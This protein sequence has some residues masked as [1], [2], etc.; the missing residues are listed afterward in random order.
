MSLRKIKNYSFTIY[1]KFLRVLFLLFAL[2]FF[3]LPFFVF[4]LKD[5]SKNSF[6]EKNE[7]VRSVRLSA[8]TKKRTSF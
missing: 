6:I 4:F 5:F 3:V 7:V 2:L 8:V 1:S